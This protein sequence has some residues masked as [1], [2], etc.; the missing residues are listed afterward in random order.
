MKNVS[1]AVAL[2]LA[3]FTVCYTVITDRKSTYATQDA[4]LTAIQAQSAAVLAQ[5][6]AAEAQSTADKSYAAALVADNALSVE[7]LLQLYQ[8][9]QSK[10]NVGGMKLVET[11]IF[12]ITSLRVPYRRFSKPRI[13]RVC[14]MLHFRSLRPCRR[15]AQHQ[16]VP[17][18]R[19]M[20]SSRRFT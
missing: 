9:C 18:T 6:A 10:P 17:L 8:I 14:S 16:L 15:S 1:A 5:S 20:G 3:I 2:P 13:V 19:R 11:S 4:H 12:K 7:N